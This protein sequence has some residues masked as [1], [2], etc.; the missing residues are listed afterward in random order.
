MTTERAAS[1]KPKTA[2]MMRLF[3]SLMRE[4]FPAAA[5][6]CNS[7]MISMINARPAASDSINGNK[8]FV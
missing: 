5:I 8:L 6:Y 1:N 3:A 2:W 4:G 7:P